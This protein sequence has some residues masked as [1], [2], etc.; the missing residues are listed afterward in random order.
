MKPQGCLG[1]KEIT[2]RELTEAVL[3]RI[4]ATDEGIG[5]Y[6]TVTA[7][8]ALAQ[9]DRADAAIAAGNATAPDRHPP[10]GQG[11]ALH[12]RDPNHLRLQDPG[13][14]RARVRRHG[15]R[16]AEGGRGRD[17][18][19]RP[20]WTSSPWGRPRKTRA[21]SSP[22]TPGTRP[23]AGR[24]QRRVG[25]GGGRRHVPGRPGVGHR[26]IHPAAGLPLRDRRA[27]ADL[28]AGVPLRPGGLCLFPG[29]D[30]P[31]GPRRAGL[32]PA[33]E[34]HRR[35]RPGGFH[36]GAQG[37]PRLHRRPAGRARRRHRGHSAGIQPAPRGSI[38]KW[39]PP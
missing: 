5:A 26:G 19:A 23:G 29:P 14:F 11:R 8:A 21:C 12:P 35:P 30:R 18:W 38:R 31:H 2:S 13:K 36:L 39:P 3:A 9:A 17:R 7:E 15:H 25:R 24:F 32:R 4:A 27:E 28:R 37:R 33:A 10:G 6:L 34:L 20:T 22:A 16:Q 1:K